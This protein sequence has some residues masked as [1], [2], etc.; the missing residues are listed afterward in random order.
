M[1]IIFLDAETYYSDEYSLRKMPTPSYILDKRFEEIMWATKINNQP[2]EIID[3]PD[4]GAWLAQHDPKD[5]I[6]VTFNSLFDN[7]ILTWHH[8]FVPALMLDSLGMVRALR[9]HVLD[10][11]SLEHVSE[12][13]GLGQ[14]GKALIKVKGMRR[15]DILRAGLYPELGAYALQDNEL[16]AGLFGM[17]IG[18]FPKSER[19]LMDLVLR[20]AIEPSFQVDKRLLVKHLRDL[21]KAKVNILY[22][23]SPHKGRPDIDKLYAD[24][25][26]ALEWAGGGQTP[27]SIATLVETAKQAFGIKQITSSN[28]FAETLTRLGVEIEYKTSPATGNPTPCFAKTDQFM[29]DL[30]EHPDPR[31]QTLAA[32]RLGVKSTIEETRTLKLLGISVLPWAQAGSL[33]SFPGNMPVPLRYGGAHTHRLSGEW[34]M[35]MQ[36]MPRG[37][38]LRKALLASVNHKV[39]AGDLSQIEARLVAWLAGCW[40]LLDEF[41]ATPS[42]PDPDPY[43]AF[44]TKVF[45]FPVIKKQHPVHRFIGKTGVLGLGYGCGDEKFYKMVVTGARLMGIDITEANFTEAL[46]STTVRA[47]R[48]D[49][50]QIPQLWRRLDHIVHRMWTGVEGS[51]IKLGPLTFSRPA[52]QS[53]MAMRVEGPGGLGLDYEMLP[54]RPGEDYMYRRGHAVHKIY[55]AKMLENVIQFLARI[56]VMN[57]ALRLNDRGYRF[58]LQAH[59]E[60]VFN[61]IPDQDVDNAKAIIYTEMTRPPSWAP[62]FPLGAEVKSGQS[63][64]DCK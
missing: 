26:A 58:R 3:G 10:R 6:S 43:S 56:I 59:D 23:A 37:S 18:E 62:D 1:K 16:N 25:V 50:Q 33:A 22:E 29:A 12:T 21:Q 48:R 17:L 36:N 14:K 15:A 5:T 41:R 49:Y 55:G 20:C 60:L 8:G 46:A 47:Y 30:A 9:G 4:M 64:G 63:Y 7:S 53:G 40:Q 28:K 24:T 52:S 38:K 31:V 32:C 35:N 51:E 34:G 42:N 13:L 27:N 61:P 39:I 45:G 57:A 44:A 11:F 19:R 2:G 54:W